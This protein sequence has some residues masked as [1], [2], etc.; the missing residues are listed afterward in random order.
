ML[1]KLLLTI[2]ISFPVTL[3]LAQDTTAHRMELSLGIHHGFLVAHRPLIVPM[4][5]DHIN[6]LEANFAVRPNGSRPWHH[7]YGFPE[8][9]LSLAVWNLGNPKQLGTGVSLIP[10]LDFPLAKGKNSSFDLKFGWGIGYVEK[11]FDADV[12]YKNV[13]IGTHWNYALILQP[14]FKTK[15]TKNLGLNLG[16]SITHFSNGSTVTPNLGINLASVTGGLSYSFGQY[17][18]VN[19]NTLPAF[20]KSSRTTFFGAVGL[21]QVYPAEGKTFFV[22]TVSG[23]HA[24]QLSP[25]SAFGAGLDVFFDTSVDQKLEEQGEELNSS[26][27]QTKL[28]LHGSYDLVISDLSVIVN[29]GVYLYNKITNDGTFY[30]RVGLRYRITEKL[31]VLMQLKTHWGKADFVEWGVGYRIDKLKSK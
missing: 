29:M 19:T 28:G 18:A 7:V 23:N 11:I 8:M 30:Q 3:V 16:L 10:Y 2:L 24:W 21:K 4:Q 26:L 6:G 9:G 31:F 20:T 5:Q 13:A 27:E 22:S 14:K 12:N 25:K 17:N 15:I 1:K